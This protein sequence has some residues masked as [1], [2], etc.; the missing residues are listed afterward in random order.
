ML[1]AITVQCP[2]CGE[3]FEIGV[4]P[5]V[6]EQRYIEDCVVCCRPIDFTV[7]IGDGSS[8]SVEAKREDE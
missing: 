5:S 6:A 3:W 1:E 8:P 2:Y 7:T 4:D